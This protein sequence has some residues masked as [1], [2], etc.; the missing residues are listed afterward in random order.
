M[1][2]ALGRRPLKVGGLTAMVLVLG[3]SML[4]WLDSDRPLDMQ[5][6]GLPERLRIG[7]WS[8]MT[9]IPVT[10]EEKTP[11]AVV[12]SQTTSLPSGGSTAPT[13]TATIVAEK[14]DATE[15]TNTTA[16]TTS[17]VP[18]VPNPVVSVDGVRE[19]LIK[20]SVGDR[21][22]N[23][24]PSIA[25]I[26][27]VF[28]GDSGVFERALKT[29]EVHN[30]LHGYPIYVLRQEILNDVWTK[31]AY[32]LSVLLKELAK[33]ESE[34]MKWL[35]WF[36]AD[37]VLMNPNIPIELFLPPD[38]F[39][40]IHLLVTNDL[41]G[42]N[43]GVF[44][45]RVHPWSVRLLSA[46]VAFT[47]FRPDTHLVFR[48][49]SALEEVLKEDTFKNNVVRLPQRWFNA[50]QSGSLK[51]SIQAYQVRR[52]D[53]LVH[54]AGSPF[55]EEAMSHWLELSEEHLPEWEIDLYHSSY[56]GE[57]KE[58]WQEKHIEAELA[59]ENFRNKRIEALELI[60]LTESQM[61]MLS[62]HLTA[63]ERDDVFREKD[64]LRNIA[65][66][67]DNTTG[68]TVE[69]IEKAMEKLKNVRFS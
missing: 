9:S 23:S 2:E 54:F 20:P 6:F 49:Q 34:R 42:L 58:F 50:Y 19:E 30:R 61:K 36:D 11:S 8:P 10:I 55:R 41:N 66:G 4:N 43:N 69:D 65:G 38:E 5:R 21:Y 56:P 27:I 26:T 37:T 57:I 64:A 1:L 53:L 28:G 51:E 3:Y 60:E 17:S 7:S 24:P 39:S 14:D 29:H 40:H 16:L 44:P 68:K 67:G 18:S 46:V 15:T 31:P 25:K 47:T 45:I 48:D 12:S 63:E 59:K 13:R 62:G 22:S 35:F 33:P 32:I 52:G